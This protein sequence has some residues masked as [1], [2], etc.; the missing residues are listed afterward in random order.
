MKLIDFAVRQRKCTIH[1]APDNKQAPHPALQ[2]RDFRGCSMN[3]RDV[4]S[5]GAVQS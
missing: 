3:R 1:A 5:F 2:K 4:I